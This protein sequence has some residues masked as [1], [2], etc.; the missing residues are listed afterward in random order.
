M[1]TILLLTHS[2]FSAMLKLA[3]NVLPQLI[4][5]FPKNRNINRLSIG[6]AFFGL[7]LGS[8]NLGLTNVAPETL[9]IRRFGFSPN[10]RYLFH[11]S[12]F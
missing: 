6:Y 12:H 2:I 10:S 5:I 11:H 1:T 8:P 3:E 9:D 7:T 4:T